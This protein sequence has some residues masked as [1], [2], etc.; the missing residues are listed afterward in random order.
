MQVVLELKKNDYEKY[1]TLMKYSN[2]K[3]CANLKNK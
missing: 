1:K 2:Y 3:S